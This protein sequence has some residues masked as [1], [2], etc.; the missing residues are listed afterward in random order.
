MCQL[1]WK[2]V[3]TACNNKQT[4]FAI[5]EMIVGAHSPPPAAHRN[6]NRRPRAEIIIIIRKVRY[7][8]SVPFFLIYYFDFN[9]WVPVREPLVQFIQAKIKQIGVS[10]F[11]Q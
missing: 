7:L 9:E 2:I 3:K 1:L 10:S 6:G 11:V 5:L 4:D 8:L